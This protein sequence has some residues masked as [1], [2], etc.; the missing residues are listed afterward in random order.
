MG[1][2]VLD[3][4]DCAGADSSA[5]RPQQGHHAAHL[6]WRSS[7][8]TCRAHTSVTAHGP[9]RALPALSAHVHRSPRHVSCGARCPGRWFPRRTPGNG[10]PGWS[11]RLA[12]FPG[13]R[14]DILNETVHRD[15]ATA[16]TDFILTA[17]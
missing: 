1:E 14:H 7:L 11:A 4:A 8:I 17:G 13:A 6:A 3:K 5:R 12:E 9:R 15:V 2:A 16:I 10:P